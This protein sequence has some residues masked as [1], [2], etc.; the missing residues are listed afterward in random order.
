MNAELEALLKAL[1]ATFDAPNEDEYKR[2]KAI[3][4]SRLEDAAE[5][6]RVT[7]NFLDQAVRQ[8]HPKWLSAQKKHPTIP[9][10]A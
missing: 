6:L 2:L 8:R 1:Q 10:K 7:T 4:E 3:Y 9:P 5:Q